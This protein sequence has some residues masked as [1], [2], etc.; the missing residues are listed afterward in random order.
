MRT[1][2]MAGALMTLLPESVIYAE[3]N[4][5]LTVSGLTIIRHERQPDQSRDR[6]TQKSRSRRLSRRRFADTWRTASCWRS[7]RFSAAIAA[8]LPSNARSRV[9]I[10]FATPIAASR[11][12]ISGAES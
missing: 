6:Q 2:I 5:A 10:M 1:V 12:G 8:R 3:T 11:F 9:T 4:L 7:A